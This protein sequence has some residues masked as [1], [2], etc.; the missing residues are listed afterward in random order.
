MF[1][2]R[3]AVYRQGAHAAQTLASVIRDRRMKPGRVDLD[4]VF[5]SL[6]RQPR[7]A[8]NSRHAS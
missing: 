4:A 3:R 1:P 2:V 6:D 8:V 7:V 5:F